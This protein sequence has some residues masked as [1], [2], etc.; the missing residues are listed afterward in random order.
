M[1]G[2]WELR[3]WILLGDFRRAG[4]TIRGGGEARIFL[5]V[6]VHFFPK[7]NLTFLVVVTFKRTLN[8]QTSKQRGKNL[9]ADR[10]GPPCDGGPS[11]STTGTMDN[12]AL[13]FRPSDPLIAHPWKKILRAPMLKVV[14]PVYGGSYVYPPENRPDKNTRERADLLIQMTSKIQ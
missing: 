2:F 7:K 12:P 3:L 13:D 4:L 6:S 10:R 8:V 9:A 1:A 11:H 5:S 14:I